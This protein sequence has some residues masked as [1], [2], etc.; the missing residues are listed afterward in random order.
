MKWIQNLSI[1]TKLVSAFLLT[2][3]F[4]A[5][6]GYSGYRAT[7][8]MAR[9][10]ETMYQSQF[11]PMEYLYRLNDNFQRTRV[12]ALNFLVITDSSEI[13]KMKRTVQQMSNR[14]DSLTAL[15]QASITDDKE[16]QYFRQ[17]MDSLAFFRAT[18]NEVI[19]LI[20]EGLRDSATVYYRK[21]PGQTASRGMYLALNALIGAKTQQT[22][23]L[24]E[25]S[26]QQFV[27]LQRQVIMITVG[28]LCVAAGL[29]ILLARGIGTPIRRL[30]E[31][32]TRV[33]QGATDV[34]VHST[35]HDELGSLASN[36]NAMVA[37]I[38]GL[39]HETR[40]KSQEHA[41]EA[42][43][44]LEARSAAEAQQRY[45]AESVE[46]ILYEMERFSQ[47]NLTV[48]LQIT[49]DD[50]IGRLYKGFNDAL[51]NIC[52]MI[53]RIKNAVLST[54]DAANQISSDIGS[55]SANARK[56]T[57]RAKDVA[58][59]VREVAESI[60]SSSAR[61]E[62]ASAVAQE[63][64]EAAR[65]GE[66]VVL[67]TLE[68]IQKIV[69]G[70]LASAQNIQ[71]LNE[72]SA[73]ISEIVQVIQEIADQTNLLALNAAI[74]AARAGDAGRG[75]AVVADEVRK[76][77]EKT[78]TA[79]KEIIRTIDQ[80]R[81][82]TDAAVR[83]IHK[84]TEQANAGKDLAEK[85][86]NALKTLIGKTSQVA[87]VIADVAAISNEQVVGSE[88]IR[89]NLSV[90]SEVTHSSVQDSERIEHAIQ[91]LNRLTA[92]LEETMQQFTV[93]AGLRTLAQLPV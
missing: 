53:A 52:I 93:P 91:E 36:F 70:V 72:S 18:F 34:R 44:A 86:D 15:Y 17:F 13:E 61:I 80:V 42:Q 31:A 28:A 85:A 1:Q 33:A 79:T 26:S 67:Q 77:A 14:F 27:E 9:N 12:Y 35:S 19:R 8:T 60:A 63:A 45:L 58:Q 65:S 32:A 90:M 88:E 83:A 46:K 25:A 54:V 21:G 64:G 39:L 20:N 49:S 3:I 68:S 66:R 55:M 41:A 47:G 2:G 75:F 76:L 29:G 89:R 7:A 78:S 69:D 5:G 57:D 6:A 92:H 87:E 4:V 84:G 16:M 24:K 56:Q 71:A 51:D 59:A 82:D 37:N 74:E 11:V 43:K 38:D 73:R 10:A 81:R 50:D 40:K 48:R 23:A 30:A 62:R 22:V